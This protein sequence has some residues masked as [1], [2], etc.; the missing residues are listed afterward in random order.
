MKIVSYNVNGI[1][2]TLRKGFVDWL[3]ANDFD[4]VGLQETKAT[5]DQVAPDELARIAALG[6]RIDW[7]SA[8]RKGYSGVATL[9]RPAV[10]GVTNGC[11]MPHVDCEG[12]VLQT[13]YADFTLLNCYFPNGGANDDRHRFKQQFMAD[14]LRYTRA[15]RQ[16]QPRLI[17]IGDYNIAHTELDIHNPKANQKSSGFLPEERAWMGE[18]FA[19]GFVDPFRQLYPD[20]QEYSWWSFR[21]GARQNNKG[22]RI[23]YTSVTENL[24]DRVRDVQHRKDDQHSDHCAVVLEMEG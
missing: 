2:A 15:L 16:R 5:V 7:H 19:D 1:R 17:I 14:F 11:A 10:E 9:S 12:R 13:D 3:A 18:W 20:K 23:D 6:Y 8:E 24:F 22:W 21:G 4:I